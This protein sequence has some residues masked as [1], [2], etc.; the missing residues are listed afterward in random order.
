MHKYTGKDLYIAFNGI[1]L[2]GDWSSLVIEREQAWA[3]VTALGEG[4]RV[5]RPTIQHAT[6]T[7]HT[8]DQSGLYASGGA[9]VQQLGLGTSGE[10]VFGPRGNAIGQPR[11]AATALLTHIAQPFAVDED[12]LLTLKG[13]LNSELT[14]ATFS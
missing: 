4:H 10:L 9:I 13:V 7:L 3:A 2:S 12:V 8:Y 6:W 1:V 14:E 11:F 5:A